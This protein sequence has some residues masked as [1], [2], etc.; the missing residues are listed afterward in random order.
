VRLTI[1][2]ALGAA[3][4]RLDRRT[5]MAQLRR[6]IQV[7][8]ESVERSISYFLAQG[9]A[10]GSNAGFSDDVEALLAEVGPAIAVDG[11]SIRPASV[12]PSRL[13]AG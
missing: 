7:K 4:R 13:G 9:R 8:L 12:V 3:Q 6:G 5:S 1:R 11:E 2:Q 10:L